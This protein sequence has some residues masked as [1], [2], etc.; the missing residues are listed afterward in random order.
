MA[1]LAKK[2]LFEKTILNRRSLS[3]RRIRRLLRLKKKADFLNKTLKLAYRTL[4]KLRTKP[5]PPKSEDLLSSTTLRS[6]RDPMVQL[7]DLSST[8]PERFNFVK[9]FPIF[10]KRITKV[11][12][13]NRSYLFRWYRLKSRRRRVVFNFKRLIKRFKIKNNSTFL[14]Y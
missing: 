11:S 5:S 6:P 7:T 8:L 13:A 10:N 2:T 14:S 3:K 9:N 4:A 1:R 12:W